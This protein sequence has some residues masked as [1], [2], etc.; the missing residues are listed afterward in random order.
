MRSALRSYNNRYARK[1]IGIVE[2]GV[3]C[4]LRAES[5]LCKMYLEQSKFSKVNTGPRFA[6]GFQPSVCMRLHNT[7]VQTTS[8]SHTKS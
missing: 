8:G 3:F 5:L 6:H 2:S 7:N 1:N 4:V